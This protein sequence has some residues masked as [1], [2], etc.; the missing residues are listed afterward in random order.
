MWYLRNFIQEHQTEQKVTKTKKIK[1]APG[2]G[3]KNS[4]LYTCKEFLSILMNF[5]FS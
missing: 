4:L 5:Y 1:E 2:S 3:P